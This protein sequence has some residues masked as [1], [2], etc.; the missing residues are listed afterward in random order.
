MALLTETPEPVTPIDKKPFSVFIVDDDESWLSAL[1]FRLMKDNSNGTKVFCY[2]SGEE[3]LRNMNLHPS[4]IILDYYLD[5]SN[6]AAMSGLQTLR[7][8][9]KADPS[10]P[11]VVLSAQGD[12]NVALEI[13]AAGAYTYI[14]KDKQAI[15]SVEKI[16]ERFR[17][18]ETDPITKDR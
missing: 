8:I 10:V 6:P 4:L 11:V 2:T 9:K 17:P 5:A 12:M 15:Q 18:A 14:I 7:K 16:I 13:Y 1:G 3:C